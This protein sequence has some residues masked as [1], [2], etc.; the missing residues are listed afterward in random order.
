MEWHGVRCFNAERYV[1]QPESGAGLCEPT[2]PACPGGGGGGINDL[3]FGGTVCLVLR[4]ACH[5]H[6]GPALSVSSVS[7]AKLN[8]N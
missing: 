2:L 3:Q 1:R 5:S 6:P 7:L 4:T 8:K